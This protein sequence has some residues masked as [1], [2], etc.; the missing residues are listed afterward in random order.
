MSD[1]IDA[2][3]T[4]LAHLICAHG[5]GA[6]FTVKGLGR[7]GSYEE[8]DAGVK[9]NLN[10]MHPQKSYT[11]QHFHESENIDRNEERI[12]AQDHRLLLNTVQDLIGSNAEVAMLCGDRVKWTGFRRINKAPRGVWVSSR[13]ATLYEMHYREVF[14]TGES[15]YF[16]RV[17]AVSKT[18]E[19][20]V[21]LIS[22]SKGRNSEIEGRQLILAASVIEDA[23]RP[24]VF[25]ASIKESAEVVLPVPIGEHKDLF[26]L[27]E[28]PLS[29][30]GRR[31]AILHWVAKHARSRGKS[32]KVEVDAYLRGVRQLSM[33]GLTVTLSPN[34]AHSF[35]GVRHEP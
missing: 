21:C 27:R 2:T 14:E 10:P 8:V 11:F 20:V 5:D 33:D 13:G 9:L 22:G 29:P 23:H 30:S 15:T 19:P 17:C 1:I 25:T 12:Y 24:S 34:E 32:N 16:K 28:A 7:G 3:E 35:H 26:S 6:K 31:K 18:G 4:L